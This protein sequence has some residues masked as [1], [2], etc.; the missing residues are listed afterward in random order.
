MF[1]I[2]LGS[3]KKLLRGRRSAAPLRPAIRPRVEAL[4]DRTLPS[5]TTLGVGPNNPVPLVPSP[6]ARRAATGDFNGDGKTDFVVATGMAN[7]NNVAVLL[8][9]T[10]GDGSTGFQALYM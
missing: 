10:N 9:K 2:W 1:R 8:S 4:E 7:A 6:G 5:F 3:A